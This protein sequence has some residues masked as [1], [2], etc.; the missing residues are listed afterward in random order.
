[1]KANF[2]VWATVAL[3]FTGC[4]VKSSDDIK[5]ETD[6]IIKKSQQDVDELTSLLYRGGQPGKIT[7]KGIVVKK[8][9]DQ[10]QLDQRISI[11]QVVGKGSSGASQGMVSEK[12]KAELSEV[13]ASETLSKIDESKT[14][15]NLGCKDLS[16]SDTDGLTEESS[17][18]LNDSVLSLSAKKVFICGSQTIA[19]NF[20]SISADQLI[21]KDAS[22]EVK[23]PVGN[24]SVSANKMTLEGNS[25]LKTSGIDST[26]SVLQAPT[27][28]LVVKSEIHG[29]GKLALQSNGGNC[30]QKDEKK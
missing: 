17:K 30:V 26:I 11:S 6:E 13:V 19:Q 28:D 22:L 4:N 1:M 16:A 7:V 29:E 12:N 2:L 10:V 15:I 23:A 25:I 27:L 18:A 24:L 21:F 5:K 14:F 8:T 9:A 20:V 3:M